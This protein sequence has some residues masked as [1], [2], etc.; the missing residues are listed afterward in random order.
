MPFW[1]DFIADNFFCNTAC[2]DHCHGHGDDDYDDEF[3]VAVN[4]PNHDRMVGTS[5]K[6]L[7][8]IEHP[9]VCQNQPQF[10][11]PW[12]DLNGNQ[13]E[14]LLT[15]SPAEKP[16]SRNATSPIQDPI[17]SLLPFTNNSAGS[18]LSNLYRPLFMSGVPTK[19]SRYQPVPT[20]PIDVQLHRALL[21]LSPEAFELFALRRVESGKY[22]IEGRSVMVYQSARGILVHENEVSGASIADMDLHAYVNLVANVA[23]DLQRLATETTEDAFF[24]AGAPTI[25]SCSDNDER[26]RAMQIACMQAKLREPLST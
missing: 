17:R 14:S 9:R 7:P 4:A 8:A 25:N 16:R 23:L 12:A 2:A 11:L 3:R 1:E 26:F 20:D 18:S 10:S 6:Q 5:L 22:E 21:G 19:A 24:D 13:K 15:T